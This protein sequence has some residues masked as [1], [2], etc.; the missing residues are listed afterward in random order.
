M[1]LL[2]RMHKGQSLIEY[3][4]VVAIVSAAFAAMSTYVFRAMQKKQGEIT[5][6]ATE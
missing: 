3:S 5:Q 6:A 1:R 2:Q 4:L